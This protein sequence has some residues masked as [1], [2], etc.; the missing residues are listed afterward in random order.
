MHI[1]RNAHVYTHTSALCIATG[2]VITWP[3]A[4]SPMVTKDWVTKGV[5]IRHK[6]CWWVSLFFYTLGVFEKHL[7]WALTSVYARRTQGGIW[8]HTDV[9]RMF[10]S[11]LTCQ[12]RYITYRTTE[13]I[14]YGI[15]LA[16]R[17][18]QC[19]YC[20]HSA[21]FTSCAVILYILYIM[22]N[23]YLT[24]RTV[25]YCT[26]L[27]GTVPH[28]GVPY[29][30]VLSLTVLYYHLKNL[31]QKTVDGCRVVPAAHQHST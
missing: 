23:T 13:C 30:T 21:Y 8:M 16:C 14:L 7:R 18:Y 28:L 4:C 22:Y 31:W 12:I 24:Y 3:F 27:Y 9:W 5:P 6:C 15:W 20:T 19:T 2:I 17:T 25:P 11:I 1:F 29:L 26:V 10:D